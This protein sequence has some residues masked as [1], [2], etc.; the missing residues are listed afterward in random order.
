MKSYDSCK[1]TLWAAINGTIASARFLGLMQT[2]K[3]IAEALDGES[4]QEKLSKFELGFE[5]RIVE[6]GKMPGTQI[7][8]LKHCPF[9]EI[10]LNIPPWSSEAMK[11]VANY[12]RN[13][14]EGGG[15]ALHPIC[16]IHR[17]IRDNMPDKVINIACRSE[18]SG[19]IVV[20]ETNLAKVGLTRQEAE[21]MI[22][23]HACLYSIN[24]PESLSQ[25]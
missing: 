6:P 8:I 25:D 3:M 9:R 19:A 7:V 17:G 11:L 24:S 14:T 12:N 10:T 13:P 22:A 15:G 5:N 23:G 2:G 21:E 20:S 16:I 18:T 1:L 4:A